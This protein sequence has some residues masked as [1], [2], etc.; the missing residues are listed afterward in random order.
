MTSEEIREKFLKYFEERGHTRVPSSSLVSEDD[1]SVLF[2]T[3]GMQQ[4]K[5]YYTGVKDPQVDFG[6]Y[7]TTSAQKCIRTSDIEE[8]GDDTHLTFFEML[9]NFSFG[10][11]AY[12]K[13]EAIAFA[14][15]FITKEMGLTIDYVSIFQGEE[16]VP[17]DDGSERIWKSLDP[18]IEV[19]EFGREDNFW[20]PTGDEGPCGPT[21]EVYVNGVEIWNIVFNEYYCDIEKNLTPLEQKG[22]DT[23]MGLER[24]VKIMQ[25]VDTIFETDL[26]VSVIIFP[27]LI[28]YKSLFCEPYSSA[29]ANPEPN[30]TPFTDGI[31]N[32][33]LLKSDSNELNIGS[34]NPTGMFVVT[35]SMIPPNESPFFL[36]SKIFS[37]ITF[38]V[39]FSGHLT[40][41]L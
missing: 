41:F 33:A 26:L 2:T 32:M 1:A 37:L 13:K 7:S 21:T 15:E 38:A 28:M 14:H 6:S 11:G 17:R 36:A 39:L 24:L 9:G 30:S 27:F 12:F 19:R 23:G 40:S 22:V 3:A 8:V 5:P 16:G 31:E 10:K 20:G 35:D 29:P 34:P 25:G 4:F 18:E